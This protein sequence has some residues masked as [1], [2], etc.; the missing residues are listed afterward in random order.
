[1]SSNNDIR[2]YI[3]EGVLEVYTEEQY[4]DLCQ[5]NPE[6]IT[7]SSK[8]LVRLTGAISG[9]ALSTEPT[10]ATRA[11]AEQQAGKAEVR[12][13]VLGLLNKIQMRADDEDTLLE[14]LKVYLPLSDAEKLHFRTNLANI[15]SDF[16]SI[17]NLIMAD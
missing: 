10:E 2:R 12:A 9:E 17:R 11:I 13:A 1:M 4:S 14:D 6:L 5:S 7:K 15:P 3:R 8:E 16:D